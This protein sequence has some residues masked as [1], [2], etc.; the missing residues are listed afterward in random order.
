MDASSISL[1]A[2]LL[3]LSDDSIFNNNGQR[4]LEED[5]N[6]YYNKLK[7]DHDDGDHDNIEAK[8]DTVGVVDNRRDNNNNEHD[9]IL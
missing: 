5:D 4:Q 3:G 2:S 9:M 7:D 8:A 6:N 1:L